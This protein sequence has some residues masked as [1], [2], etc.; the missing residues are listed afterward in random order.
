MDFV[1]SGPLKA[2]DVTSGSVVACEW[3]VVLAAYTHALLVSGSMCIWSRFSCCLQ[4]FDHLPLLDAQPSE[5]EV[6]RIV[7]TQRWSA[8]PGPSNGGS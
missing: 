4:A 2:G 1:H 5:G 3:I 8:Q 7:S 6:C